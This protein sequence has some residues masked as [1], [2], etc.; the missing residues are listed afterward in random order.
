MA[1]SRSSRDFIKNSFLPSFSSVFLG[2]ASFSLVI[3]MACCIFF[4]A[5]D[6]RKKSLFL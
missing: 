1:G 5:R 2:V 6:A 3:G 4:P